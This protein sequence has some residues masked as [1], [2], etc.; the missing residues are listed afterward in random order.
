MVKKEKEMN[1]KE[2]REVCERIAKLEKE[3]G[4]GLREDISE[5]KDSLRRI[6]TTLEN[7]SLSIQATKT[8]QKVQWWFIGLIIV[9]F[10][11]ARFV[12]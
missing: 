7:L 1:E 5:M 12:K 10:F 3:V 2:F 11:V 6:Q 9:S 4:N 8:M